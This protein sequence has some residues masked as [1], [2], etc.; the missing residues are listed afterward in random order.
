MSPGRRGWLLRACCRQGR[1]HP[2]P[3]GLRRAPADAYARIVNTIAEW[4]ALYA[5]GA[6]TVATGLVAVLHVLEPEFDPSWRMLSEYVLGRYGILMRLAFLAASTGVM[7][8]ALAL[9]RPAGVGPTLFLWLVSLGPFGAAFI[10]TDP[11]TTPTEAMSTRGKVHAALGSLFILGFPLAATAVGVSTSGEP[12]VG[13]TLAVA[14]A[15]PWAALV[16]FLAVALRYQRPDHPAGPDV[17]IGWPNR[18]S[19]VAYL[20][21]VVLGAAV[22]L[23]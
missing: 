10:D 5:V 2:G 21:W 23:R 9:S 13:S 1:T 7:A 19:M 4:E 14:S 3:S 20:G 22:V 15:V 18:L 16:L 11:I 12:S 8:V 17:P 6:V